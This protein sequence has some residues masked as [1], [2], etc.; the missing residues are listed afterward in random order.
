MVTVFPPNI[1][2]IFTEKDTKRTV[3]TNSLKRNALFPGYII[4][5]YK[6]RDLGEGILRDITCVTD[7]TGIGTQRPKGRG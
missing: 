6:L 7:V 1:T 2:T 4:L 5:R 3:K